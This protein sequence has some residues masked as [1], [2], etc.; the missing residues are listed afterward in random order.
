MSELVL[1]FTQPGDLICDPFMG[2]GTTGIACVKTH[3]RFVGI[4]R[5]PKWFDLACRRISD[6]LSRPDLFIERPVPPKQ[7]GLAL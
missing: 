5:D 4:E 1:D 3:R 7:E 6:R 2:S